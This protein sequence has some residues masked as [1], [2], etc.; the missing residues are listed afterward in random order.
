L[1]LLGCGV[2]AASPDPPDPAVAPEAPTSAPEAQNATE[3]DA[4]PDPAAAGCALAGDPAPAPTLHPDLSAVAPQYFQPYHRGGF[5]AYRG[6]PPVFPW[7]DRFSLQESVVPPR[8]VRVTASTRSSLLITQGDRGLGILSRA[9]D[10]S[11]IWLDEPLRPVEAHE[12]TDGV[13]WALARSGSTWRVVRIAE[14][15]AEVHDLGVPVSTWDVRVALD[16]AERPVAAWVERE[17]GVVRVRVTFDL[18]PAHAVT[19]DEVTLPEPVAALSV[20]SRVNLAIAAEG[21]GVALAWRPLAD[22]SFTDVGTAM[23][24]PTTPCAAEVRWLLLERDGSHA[25]P[26]R[27]PTRAH[28]LLGTSGIG[29]WGLTGNGM[30][31]GR[32]AG[33]AVFVWLDDDGVRGAVVGGAPVVLAEDQAGSLLFVHEEQLFLLNSSPVAQALALRCE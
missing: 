21:D 2:G 19:A 29:P 12:A 30:K 20:R 22:A 16:A 17:A 27:H 10:A 11:P 26:E 33:H 15:A 28:P 18:D 25:E 13:I 23:R 31:A 24:P 32:V 9:P 3:E 8:G 1:A 14:G 7:F 5:D 6:G 4:T